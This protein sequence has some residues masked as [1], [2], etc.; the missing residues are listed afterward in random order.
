MNK[1][2]WEDATCFICDWWWLILVG[3]LLL[4]GW[5]FFMQPSQ[6]SYAPSAV[7]LSWN[8]NN[9]LDLKVVEPSGFTIEHATPRSSSGGTFAQDANKNCLSN[10]SS[11][12]PFEQIIW[13]NTLPNGNYKLVVHFH[14]ACAGDSENFILALLNVKGQE[15]KTFPGSVTTNQSQTF[16]ITIPTLEA[17]NE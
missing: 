11:N 15:I 13:P 9:D 5:P 16:C 14:Q 12:S 8:S 17:C 6:N 7:R 4:A 1:A 10:Q 3:I 2:W